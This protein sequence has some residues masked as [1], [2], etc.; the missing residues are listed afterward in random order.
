MLGASE[1]CWPRL[2]GR[3]TQNFWPNLY[4]GCH[5]GASLGCRTP[6]GVLLV[7]ASE[8]GTQGRNTS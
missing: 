5:G 4:H 3:Q 8:S 1:D 6:R 2:A 7:N